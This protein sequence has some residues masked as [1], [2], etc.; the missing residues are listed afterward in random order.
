M[1]RAWRV[2]GCVLVVLLA[3]TG[4]GRSTRPSATAGSSS[5]V[6]RTPATRAPTST[7]SSGAPA[8]GADPDNW[9][10]YA[11][12]PQ[13]T[14]VD[15]QA[16]PATRLTRSWTAQLDGA[17][18]AQPLVVAGQV[19]V[20]TEQ[21][22]VASLAADSGRILWTTRLGA[23]VPGGS[24]P[25][26]DIDPSGITATPVVDTSTGTVWVL[27]FVEQDGHPSHRLVGLRLDTG[28]V[29]S[30]RPAEVPGSD[31]TVEQAR[32]ALTL[33]AGRVLIPYGGLYGDCGPYHGAVVGLPENGSGPLAAWIVPTER[34]GGIW[35]PP[36]PVIGADG[37]LLVSTGNA[38]SQS[39]Y[40]EANAVV[41]LSPNLKPVDLFA[42]ANW[43]ALSAA[44]QDESSTSPSLLNDGQ[45]VTV[46]K[47]GTGYL[48]SGAHLGGVGGQKAQA[49]VCPGRG[50]YG[51]TAVMGSVVYEP[52]LDGLRAVQ[53]GPGAAFAVRWKSDVAD[54]GTP[55]VAGGLVWLVDRTGDVVGLDP[56]T[57]A[58]RRR[59]S[60]GASFASRFP[61][62]SASGGRL[63]VPGGPTVVGFT[64]A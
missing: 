44:D 36:G 18:L 61:T 56:A 13:R 39:V 53:I 50:A 43:R 2:G 21:D 30:T 4:C 64:G 7:A 14:G 27:A 10:T 40:D 31:P 32:G 52:C 58:V 62:L 47:E 63:F 12:D 6:T 42:P 15:A 29:T 8:A 25:C 23:P 37:T 54:P 22:T 45:V 38:A 9:L 60:V 5:T 28:A 26:G 17:I 3:A 46:G 19:I 1:Q 51:G 11:H 20:A 16:P 59:A 41:R 24:L 34:E 55:V 49:A 48:L 35:A 33:D 57:G